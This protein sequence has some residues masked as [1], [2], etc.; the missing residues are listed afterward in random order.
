VIAVLRA[1][2]DARSVSQPQPASFGLLSGTFSP[3]R[4]QMRST[5][6]SLMIQP[7]CRSSPAYLKSDHFVGADQRAAAGP[8]GR[9]NVALERTR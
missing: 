3:S 9:R 5:H 1:Q 7:A 6:L 2:P 4:R 8:L